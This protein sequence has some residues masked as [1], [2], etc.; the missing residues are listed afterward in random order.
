VRLRAICGEP[1]CQRLTDPGESRCLTHRRSSAGYM[2]EYN[3]RPGR[4]DATAFYG[5]AA[6]QHIATRYRRAH[7]ICECGPT[8]CPDGCGR[9]AVDVDHIVPRPRGAPLDRGRWDAEGNLQALARSPCHRRK[10]AR[11]MHASE[12]TRHK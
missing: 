9:E 8:C 10:T 6:W 5:T 2:R 11:E 1:T 12:V 4:Q 3:R 7:P